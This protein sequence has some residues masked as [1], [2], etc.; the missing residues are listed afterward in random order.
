LRVLNAQTQQHV[1]REKTDILIDEKKKFIPIQLFQTY[2]KTLRQQKEIKS[3]K[4]G[5]KKKGIIWKYL[6]PKESHIRENM[7]TIILLKK[8]E[9]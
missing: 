2:S 1:E 4:A 9:I 8:K 6:V 3:S 7:I 5:K